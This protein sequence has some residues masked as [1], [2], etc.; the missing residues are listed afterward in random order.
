MIPIQGS[1]VNS[2]TSKK[3]PNNT[4]TIALGVWSVLDVVSAPKPVIKAAKTAHSTAM[5]SIHH[6]Y[7]LRLARPSNRA[8]FR[9]ARRMALPKETP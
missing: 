3:T 5:P 4:G 1:K 7:S 6:Q 9:N 8:Y 2:H